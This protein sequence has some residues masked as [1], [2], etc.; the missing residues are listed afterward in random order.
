MAWK[1]TNETNITFQVAATLKGHTRGVTSLVVGGKRLYSGSMDH[2]I[3]VSCPFMIFPCC[4]SVLLWIVIEEWYNLIIYDSL[5]L[6]SFLFG[7]VVWIAN[8]TTFDK[9]CMLEALWLDPYLILITWCWLFV[10]SLIFPL[11][12]SWI[13]LIW[14]AFPQCFLQA[15]ITFHCLQTWV[16]DF[17]LLCYL[18]WLIELYCINLRKMYMTWCRMLWIDLTVP[19]VT[20]IFFMCTKIIYYD[21]IYI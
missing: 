18:T 8:G 17:F 13:E 7:S 9:A 11:F 5:L 21:L 6:S 15:K 2:T 1:G 20:V 19:L 12:K 10:L 14:S 16:T 4:L 3:R